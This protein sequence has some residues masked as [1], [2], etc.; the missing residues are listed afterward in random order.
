MSNEACFVYM[1]AGSKEEASTIGRRLVEEKLAACVNII[2]GMTSIYRWEG[3]LESASESVLIAKTMSKNV[4][5]LTERV[6]TLHSY[7]C[8]CIVTL[9]IQNGNHDFLSWINDQIYN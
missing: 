3:K 9:D 1:T 2:D 7:D 8:P 6:K 4:E 5:S